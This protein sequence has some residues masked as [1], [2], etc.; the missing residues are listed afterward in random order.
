A[1]QG[2]RMVALAPGSAAIDAG[3]DAVRS[4]ADLPAGLANGYQAEA[5]AV[6]VLPGG[7]GWY[8]GGGDAADSAGLNPGTLLGAVL[9]APGLAGQAFSFSG[10]GDVSVPDSPSLT[11]TGAV[12]VD[13]WINPSSLASPTGYQ[14][15]VAKSGPA[16]R[17]FGLYLTNSGA[18]HLT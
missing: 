8:R 17:N 16:G 4:P 11:F 7:A 9:F 18:L 6:A 14:A 13:A 2:G 5:D 15:I 1:G 3:D 10:N 12:A